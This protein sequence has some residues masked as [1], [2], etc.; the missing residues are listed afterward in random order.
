L[1]AKNAEGDLTFDDKLNTT[2]A[3]GNTIKPADLTDAINKEVAR[4]SSKEDELNTKIDDETN[5]AKNV[6]NE[7][8]DKIHNYYD[9]AILN[10]N[11]DSDDIYPGIYYYVDVT[12][13]SLDFYI[14]DKTETFDK[15]FIYPYK[16][17]VTT[18]NITLYLDDNNQTFENGNQS[19][20][21]NERK[22]IEFV[23]I[24]KTWI[25][26]NN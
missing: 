14:T 24:D 11:N 21:L 22:K 9:S 17:D 3:D 18:N 10:K 26:I 8:I 16:G 6:E 19:F 1:R 25:Y 23:L 20:E 13:Y 5:R 12:D 15:I 7:K 2:D 4:A